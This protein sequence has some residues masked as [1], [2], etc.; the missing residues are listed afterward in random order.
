MISI[1]GNDTRSPKVGDQRILISKV[2]GAIRAI[3]YEQVSKRRGHPGEISAVRTVK[4]DHLLDVSSKV[5]LAE[6]R[7]KVPY[8]DTNV[9]WGSKVQMR[10]G[11]AY[12]VAIPLRV[13]GL[14]QKPATLTGDIG[15]LLGNG[16]ATIK[17]L[18]WSN[19]NTAM[20]FDA[21][22]ESLLEPGLWGTLEVTQ[23]SE[24][25]CS[26]NISERGDEVDVLSQGNG[27]LSINSLKVKRAEPSAVIE[28]S[29]KGGLQQRR[30]GRAGYVVFRNCAVGWFDDV[31]PLVN[32]A[33]G[34]EFL[35]H[36]PGRF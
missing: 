25:S 15:V 33:K 17:R 21:S 18:F 36:N 23:H 32:F 16:T 7:A 27:E 24:T 29:G 14:E 26:P 13:L 22:T 28:W 3:H 10:N 8:H 35:P 9:V 12:E 19:K 6:G 30:I 5:R 11:Y 31:P 2:N 4:F 34:F 1:T 20:L